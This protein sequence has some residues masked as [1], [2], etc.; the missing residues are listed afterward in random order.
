MYTNLIQG[1]AILGGT[2][3]P[4]HYGHLNLALAVKNVLCLEKVFLLPCYIPV[5][6]EK[7][8]V[9]VLHR[10]EML[11][12]AINSDS[13]FNS[14]LAIDKREILRDTPSYAYDTLQEL[15]AELGD[16]LPIYFIMGIDSLISLPSWHKWQE[17][18][19]LSNLV[20]SYR[21]P[22]NHALPRYIENYYLRHK[23]T[24]IDEIRSSTRGKILLSEFT[25]NA[26]SATQIR[27]SILNNILIHDMLPLEVFRYIK[28]HKLYI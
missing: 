7:P 17:I 15:R 9:S 1:Y 11:E 4:V 6:R 3:N 12:I 14:N 13:R 27:S 19:K 5:H 26:T 28:Q 8:S 25:Y 21:P 2:F 20:V 24:N 10:L 16:N 18:I 22:A 23:S